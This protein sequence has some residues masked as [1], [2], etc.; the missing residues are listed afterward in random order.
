MKATPKFLLSLI[1]CSIFI[2]INSNAFSQHEEKAS[3]TIKSSASSTEYFRGGMK[4]EK[5]GNDSLIIHVKKHDFNNFSMKGCP[6]MPSKGKYNGHW[7][8]FD[9]GWNG[10]VNSDFTMTYPANLQYLNLKSS[11]SMTVNLNPIELNL[12]LVKN[13]FGL[14][15][16]LGFSLNNYFFSDSYLLLPD[17]LS[18]IAFKLVDEKGNVASM[19]VNKLFVSWLTLPIIFEF[20]TNPKVNI[21]SF[22]VSVGVIGGLRLQTYTKQEFKND[23]DMTYYLQDQSGKTIASVYIDD[24]YSR[25][26][27]QFHLNP[28]K[29]D[30]T[31]RIG[32]SFLNLWSTYTITPMFQKNQGPELYTWAVG[33]TLVGW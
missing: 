29:L 11:R 33:I 8:G 31:M 17:S 30:A 12:N 2:L 23:N 20:Q 26:H 27:S 9:L 7:A 19:R 14:T 21:N 13:H 32:W 18:I 16:G 28:F 10:Y 6:L 1:L 3:D 4:V 5:I 25:K 22:H 15:S 24:K